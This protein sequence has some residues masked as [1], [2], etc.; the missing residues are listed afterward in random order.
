MKTRLLGLFAVFAMSLAALGAT[1]SEPE[2]LELS[3]SHYPTHQ[4][5]VRMSVHVPTRELVVSDYTEHGSTPRYRRKMSEADLKKL[6]TLAIEEL[7]RMDDDNEPSSFSEERV[8]LEVRTRARKRQIEYLS[9]ERLE[10]SQGRLRAMTKILSA[11]G[12]KQN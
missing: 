6:C 7:V 11:Y 10:D 3:I 1:S 4:T 2:I 8:L 9:L 5:M 12:P